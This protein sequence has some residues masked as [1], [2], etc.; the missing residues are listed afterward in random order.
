MTVSR[1]HARHISAAVVPA[2]SAFTGRMDAQALNMDGQSGVFLQPLAEDVPSPQN[3]FGGPKRIQREAI[4]AASICQSPSLSSRVAY[5]IAV[6]LVLAGIIADPTTCHAQSASEWTPATSEN[7]MKPDV[8][9]AQDETAKPTHDADLTKENTRRSCGDA[10]D[11]WGPVQTEKA[12]VANLAPYLLPYLNNG[13]VFGLPGTDAGDFW[14][15]TQLSGDWCGIRTDLARRGFFFDLY[16]TSAYQSVASGGL[17]TGNTFIQ[18]TQLSINV[19]T[20][21]AGLWS[22]GVF[23]ITLESRS[24]SSPQDT[25]TVGSTAPQYTGLT[26]PGP[27]FVH[28][29][30]PTEYFLFQSLTPKFGVILGKV[31][32]LTHADQTLFGNN[33]KY[34]FANLN[35][36]KN[37]MA[38]NFYNTTSLAAIG[39]WTPLK[40]LTASAGVYDPN[41]QADNVAKNAFDRV[42]VYAI[43][44]FSYK[45]G[46]LP[47]QSWAQANWTNKPKIDLTSP[48]RQLSPSG[49][50]QAVGVLL[51]NPSAQALPINYKG[52]SWVTIGN[53]SQYLFVKDHAGAV[54]EKLGSGQ[55][56]RGIGLFGRI[57]YAPEETNP[58]TRD[59]S[60]ALFANGLS[61]HR[62][63]DSFGLG[64]YHN[65][66]SQ[67]LKNDIA[68]L[69]GATSTLKNEQGVEVFYSVAITP[70]MRLIPSYQHIWNPM[71]AEVAKNERAANV[72]LLRLSLT[73]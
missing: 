41:S 7:A 54:A 64:I 24:G 33:Y 37:P 40:W 48:F 42:N 57:G 11:S 45:I 69:T 71:T 58:I 28:N 30:L 13:P 21:R 62:P 3:K 29:V 38:L 1:I 35:F 70:A 60:V 16:S 9:A 26:I 73:F 67:P 14:H 66:I 44:I 18:N 59:A 52:E 15:R 43:A 50:P 49:V 53:F 32:V 5:T 39:V 22:G 34:D 8:H 55:P 61:D 19:D 56:L 31:N 12:S 27:F 65:G 72:F 47:G 10:V 63:N 4:Q 46:N 68:R 23:H 25:F 36:N 17:K 51:G 6:C 2:G 20:G